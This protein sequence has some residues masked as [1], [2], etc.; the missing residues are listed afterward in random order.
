KKTPVR[1]TVKNRR[2]GEPQKVTST[3]DRKKTPVRETA[4]D[5]QYEN[6]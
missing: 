1:A 5:H 4:K 6:P 3:E 2:Y